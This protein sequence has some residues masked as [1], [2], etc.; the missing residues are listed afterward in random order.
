MFGLVIVIISLAV[1]SLVMSAGSNYINTD[2]LRSNTVKAEIFG[3]VSQHASGVIQFNLLFGRS[4]SA[5]SHIS[6]ALV[7]PP[8]MPLGV[9]LLQIS[10]YTVS[11]GE[12][13]GLCYTADAVDYY[14][15]LAISDLQSDMPNGKLLITSDCSSVTEISAPI[16]YPA[17]FSFIYL[18]KA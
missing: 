12:R 7:D 4:P 3:A 6:P 14:T 16:A 15:Y 2:K 5:P 1:F 10:N 18:I 11:S 8:K 13:L 17:N 9:N